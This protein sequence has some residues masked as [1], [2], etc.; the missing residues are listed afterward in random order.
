MERKFAKQSHTT[1]TNSFFFFFVIR[2]L[3]FASASPQ[4]NINKG[5]PYHSKVKKKIIIITKRHKA[6]EY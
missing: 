1:T 6:I 5:K 3:A 4:I 2:G